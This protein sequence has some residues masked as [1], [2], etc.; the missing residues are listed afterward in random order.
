M[1][2]SITLKRTLGPMA[3]IIYGVGDILGAGIYALTGK[4]AGIAGDEA[5]LAFVGSM[6]VASLQPVPTRNS[7]RVTPTAV[8][9]P[10]TCPVLRD[11]RRSPCLSVGSYCVRELC[12]WRRGVGLLRATYAPWSRY[13][14]KTWW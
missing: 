4:V 12:R 14:L 8:V 2:S 3:L 13:C 9:R 7:V 1:S 6:I 5:W 11:A 10:I